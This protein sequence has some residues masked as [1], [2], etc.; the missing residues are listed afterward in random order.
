MLALKEL[1]ESSDN[2]RKYEALRRIGASNSML[3]RA[4]FWQI[5]IFFAFP[6]AI[7]ILHSTF[8]LIFC[9]FLLSTLGGIDITGALPSVVLVL[10]I[11]YGSYFMITYCSSRRIIRERRQ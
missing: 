9:D 2:A 8:G 1:S 4:L 11:I 10:F 7:A 6:L 3:N 5:F